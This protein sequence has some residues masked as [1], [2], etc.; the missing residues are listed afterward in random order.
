MTTNEQLGEAAY[1]A[2]CD[3][4]GWK[5]VKGEALPK[6]NDQS[7]DLQKAWIAAALAAVKLSKGLEGSQYAKGPK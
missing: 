1:N 5:S 4:V 6:W 7:P 3:S 2:Y